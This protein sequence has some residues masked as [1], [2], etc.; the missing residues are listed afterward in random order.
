[1]RSRRPTVLFLPGLLCDAALWASQ[2]EGLRDIADIRVADLTL[3]DSIAAMARRAAAAAGD[4]RFVIVALSMGGYVAFDL[5]RAVSD[6]IAGVALLDTAAT[7]DTPERAAERRA[8]IASL[9]AG[10]FAGVTSRL[11][12]KLVHRDRVNGPVG[13]AV[14]AMALRVGGEAY[15]R[16]QRAILGRPDSR[17]VLKEVRAPTLVA[18]GAQ[19]LLTPPAEAQVIRDGIAGSRYHVF[20][21]CGHLPPLELPGET[22]A[23]LRDWLVGSVL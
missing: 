3:D 17:P 19:D 9:A 13:A 6:R 18:V 5:L 23:L 7:P 15:L 4:G 16:Q 10:R 8:G 12:P 22:T 1:M 2:I 21:G 11:L 20:S 14:R